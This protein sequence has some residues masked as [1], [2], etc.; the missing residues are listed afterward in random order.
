M[1][2]FGADDILIL[3]AL[4]PTTA[5]FVISILAHAKFL[6]IR[7]V[8]DIPVQ[9]VTTGLKMVLATE[10]LFAAACTLVKLSMLMLVRRM[11]ANASVFW[12][13]IIKLAIAIV[14]IQGTVFCFTVMFQCRPPQD[15]WK[16]TVDPQPNCI[17]Q[18]SSLLA[19]GI[20]NTLTD[21]ICVILPIRTVW[22]L[23]LQARQMF[24]VITLF[25]L[26]FASCIAGCV[27]TYYMYKVLKTWDTTWASFPVWVSAA[28]ELYIGIICASIPATKPFFTTYLPAVFGSMT[29]VS[30]TYTPYATGQSRCQSTNKRVA[31]DEEEMLDFEKS[32]RMGSASEYSGTHTS[33]VSVGVSEID[34]AGIHITHTVDQQ[35]NKSMC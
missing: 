33:G 23:Q 13:R 24:I 7:H 20:I 9:N 25:A 3:C 28:V 10:I 1:R 16:I 31:T 30:L 32:L 17:N 29:S 5:F 14:T 12:T 19:A 34:D 18:G 6:W 26:G 2:V 15:Y 4:I 22:H 35:S 11:L 27:R 21:F 8:Y